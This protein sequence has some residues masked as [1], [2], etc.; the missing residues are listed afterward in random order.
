MVTLAMMIVGWYLGVR[1][2]YW[3]E[4][5]RQRR[6]PWPVGSCREVF[7]IIYVKSAPTP[8]AGDESVVE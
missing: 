4:E 5:R 8:C 6:I 2:A 3:L 1:V 7:R